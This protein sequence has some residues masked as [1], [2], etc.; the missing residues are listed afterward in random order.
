MRKSTRLFFPVAFLSLAG[1][2]WFVNQSKNHLRELRV[3]TYSSLA[4]TWGAGPELVR[5]FEKE[6]HCTVHLV[7]VKEGGLLLQRLQMEKNKMSADVILGLDQARLKAAV[8]SL[9]FSELPKPWLDEVTEK[10]D[11]RLQRWWNFQ[12]QF[13]AFD[14]APL[15]FLQREPGEKSGGVETKI[16]KLADYL[17][18]LRSG[19]I[20]P[21]PRTST[22]GLQFLFWA[23]AEAPHRTLPLLKSAKIKTVSPSWSQAYGLFQKQQTNVVFSYLT[24]VAYHRLEEKDFSV[25]PV[26]F[27]RHPFHLEYAAVPDQCMNCE[28]AK[29]FVQFLLSPTAQ[30]ILMTKNYMLPTMSEIAADSEFAKLPPVPLIEFAEW[31][32]ILE[33]QEQLLQ[34]WDQF[35]KA[36]GQ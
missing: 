1:L 35:A 14:W 2:I 18:T 28:L 7:D 26:H 29:E 17:A 8:S 3:Y 23:A 22:V 24:S 4:A 36:V 31:T 20:L 5:E 15:T 32:S 6:C 21:N 30:K 16:Y 34:E 11:S 9:S 10:I 12:N 25:Q 13:V 27:D 33:R 19:W